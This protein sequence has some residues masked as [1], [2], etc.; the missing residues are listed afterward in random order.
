[1]NLTEAKSIL[2]AHQE[3]RRGDDDSPVSNPTQL[4]IAIDT[5]LE[6]L[7]KPDALTS[8]IGEDDKL[9]QIVFTALGEASMCWSETPRGIFDSVGATIV[10]DKLLKDISEYQKSQ[11]KTKE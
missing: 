6:H 3:W 7:D 11:I 5:I 1:M 10:G 8:E 4:G 2:K 9:R